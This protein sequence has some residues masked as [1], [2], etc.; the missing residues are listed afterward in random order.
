MM[1]FPSHLRRGTEAKKKKG[2]SRNP[3]LSVRMITM[4]YRGSECP[5]YPVGGEGL[6]RVSHRFA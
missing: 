1:P 3:K 6:S 2:K 4:A 5:G